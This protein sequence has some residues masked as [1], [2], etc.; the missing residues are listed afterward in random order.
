MGMFDNLICDYPLPGDP[1]VATVSVSLWQKIQTKT[2]QT[3]D[4]QRYPN[5]E[6]FRITKDGKLII[7]KLFGTY[8]TDPSY[9]ISP[10]EGDVYMFTGICT[11]YDFVDNSVVLPSFSHKRGWIEFVA[12]FGDGIL[13]EIKLR[14]YENP[15]EKEV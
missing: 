13:K 12:E 15:V 8:H 3:K 5:L 4:L 11:F 2:F 9:G 6:T 7:Q 14:T 10:K 1:V